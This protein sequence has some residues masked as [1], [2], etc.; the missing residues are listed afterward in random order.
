M[1]DDELRAALEHHR[2]GR[3]VE[4]E[5]IY[6]RVLQADPRQPDALH[7]LGMLA[8]ETGNAPAAHQLIS[9][10][11]AHDPRAGVFRAN[12]GLVLDRLGRRDEAMLALR[13]A[14]RLQPNLP[15]ARTNYATLLRQ[16]GQFDAAA[17]ALRGGVQFTP[18]DATLWH[19][20]GL[21]LQEGG[22]KPD[23]IATYE[24]TLELD[25]SHTS[26]MNNSSGAV[27]RDRPPGGITRTV[28]T[29]AAP[30]QATSRRRG[31]TWP[32]R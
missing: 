14:L 5:A 17:D 29:G 23:A 21:V 9:Q 22:R 16:A 26:A 24:R 1:F 28:R 3:L 2:A 31:P 30:L 10:A 18:D 27:S 25:P 32:A 19:D 12:L 7:L 15:L 13:E 4:A 6:R 11:I 8:L 20:L